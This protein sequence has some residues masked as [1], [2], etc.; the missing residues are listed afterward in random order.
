M[1]IRGWDKWQTYR[2]DRG[3]PPWIKVHR[4]LLSNQE[5]ATLSDC[6]KG[7]LIS[8]WILAADKSGE[9]PDDPKFIQKMCMLDS[10]PDV[11]KFVELGFLLPCGCHDDAMMTPF[12]RSYD[13]PETETE[14]E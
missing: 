14:A 2:K 5:W 13:A 8:M 3:T 12:G 11:H 10:T 7:Q 4:N 1:R 9:I 6:E